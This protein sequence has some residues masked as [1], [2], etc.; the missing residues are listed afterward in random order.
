MAVLATVLITIS[1]NT[2]DRRTISFIKV[3]PIKHG[4]IVV[5]TMLIIL[6]TNNLAAGVVLV[7]LLNY[8]IQGFNKRKGRDI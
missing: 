1:L 5:L 6:S 4:A 7:S 3:S 8:L 2:F